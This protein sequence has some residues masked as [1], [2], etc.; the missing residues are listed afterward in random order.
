MLMHICILLK[1]GLR[2]PGWM[3]S[4]LSNE[5]FPKK[6]LWGNPDCQHCFFMLSGHAPEAEQPQENKDVCLQPINCRNSL[7]AILGQPITFDHYRSPH[8]LGL[9]YPAVIFPLCLQSESV[10]LLGGKGYIVWVPCLGATPTY[11]PNGGAQDRQA[12]CSQ[13]GLQKAF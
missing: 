6:H 2:G 1:H 8:C 5:K 10:L 4:L 9:H 12:L 7:Q 13:P 3:L 11:T